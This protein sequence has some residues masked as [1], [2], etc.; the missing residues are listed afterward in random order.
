MLEIICSRSG[1]VFEAENRRKKVHPAISYYTNHKDTGIRYPA[2]RVIDQGSAE[3]WATLE[4]F[5]KA[6]AAVL[7]P[8]PEPEVEY[9]FEGAW[10]ALITGFNDHYGYQREFLRAA[11]TEGRFKY[12]WY[13]EA[14]IVETCYKSAKGND[15][16]Y[17]RLIEGGKEVRI[18]TEAE[19]DE[20]LGEA[21]E[22]PEAGVDRTFE[23]NKSMGEVGQTVKVGEEYF[24]IVNT[25]TVTT[26]HDEDGIAHTGGY[27]SGV[28]VLYEEY[29][30]TTGVRNATAEEVEAAQYEA[31]IKQAA[32]KAVRR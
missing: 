21:P 19:V 3:G 5:E 10:V 11:K 7:N 32:R 16:R 22:A 14:G 25:S 26:Y 30:V 28:Y 2:T 1:L 31:E 8:E 27:P 24:V 4:E 6:I 12:F 13:P 23:T 29:E 18:L 20:M 9:A 15:T 17:F